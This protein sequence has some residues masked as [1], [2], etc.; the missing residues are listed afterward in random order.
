MNFAMPGSVVGNRHLVAAWSFSAGRLALQTERP[1]ARARVA[2]PKSANPNA[3]E[4]PH[5]RFDWTAAFWVQVI[6]DIPRARRLFSQPLNTFLHGVA[7]PLGMTKD[8]R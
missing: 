1:A 3:P 2:G 7:L 4:C 5:T 8:S 6:G